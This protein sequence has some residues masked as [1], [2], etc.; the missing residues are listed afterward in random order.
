MEKLKKE[1]GSKSVPSQ[2]LY[3]V[4]THDK[5]SYLVKMSQ[6]GLLK[7]MI[8]ECI[9]LR[10]SGQRL[11]VQGHVVEYN[12]TQKLAVID[13]GTAMC[14]LFLG[15]DGKESGLLAWDEFLPRLGDYVMI[16][17]TVGNSVDIGRI[18]SPQATGVSNLRRSVPVSLQV[19][20]GIILQD[21]NRETLW[22]AEIVARNRVNEP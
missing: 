18:G 8:V 21:P 19:F 10:M 11:W 5:S 2:V 3:N 20:Q 1:K 13:D 14:T 16:I 12:T 9:K 22:W 4:L 7:M 15:D 17:G 6:T